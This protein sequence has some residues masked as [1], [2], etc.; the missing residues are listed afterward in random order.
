MGDEEA[1]RAA[2]CA[3]NGAAEWDSLGGA[4]MKAALLVV[5]GLS[6][7]LVTGAI[8]QEKK[9]GKAKEVTLEGKITCA[10]CDLGKESSCMTVIVVKDGDK[11][12]V[13]YF[14]KESHKKNHSQVCKEAKEGSVKGKTSE[15]GGKKT[16]TVTKVEFK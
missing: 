1:T 3:A 13:Y 12:V 5:L 16:V 8:A 10:K 15:K 2:G 14:D 7:A 4:R 11:E 9:E 6:L